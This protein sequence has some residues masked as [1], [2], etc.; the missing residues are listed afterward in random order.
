MKTLQIIIVMLVCLTGCYPAI[1]G[2]IIDA[3]TERPIE[4]AVVLVEWTK[5]VGLPGLTHAETYKVVEV[6]T[7]NNGIATID[8]CSSYS[9]NPPD[10][11]IYKKNYVA[12]NNKYIFPGLIKRTDFTWGDSTF[13]IERFKNTYSY[14]DHQSFIDGVASL[15]SEAAKKK[16]FIKAYE[17]SE[18][19]DVMNERR[20]R[21]R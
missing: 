11:T 9:V 20:N 18:Q 15:S 8:G 4:G 12:W 10:V 1:T 21:S 19:Q 2:R 7:D 14:V 17:D 3:E 13:K 6:V 5:T 16:M